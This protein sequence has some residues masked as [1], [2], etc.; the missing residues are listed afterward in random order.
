MPA[1]FSATMRA[2][3]STSVASSRNSSSVA[4]IGW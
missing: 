4:L 3:H 1:S 2:S